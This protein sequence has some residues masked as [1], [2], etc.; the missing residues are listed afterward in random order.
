MIRTGIDA[1]TAGW[2][3]RREPA[4]RDARANSRPTTRF[5]TPRKG[6]IRGQNGRAETAP[7]RA[8]WRLDSAPLCALKLDKK[9][10]L[11]GGD[12]G[13]Y[14]THFSCQT[15]PVLPKLFR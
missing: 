12:F 5:V 13:L 7:N 8:S 15:T 1:L 3:G 14:G 6:K 9:Q 10:L 11:T 4:R 2:P